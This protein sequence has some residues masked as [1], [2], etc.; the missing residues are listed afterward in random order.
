VSGDYAYFGG[1]GND[2]FNYMGVDVDLSTAATATLHFKVWFDI[3]TDWDYAYVA[4][5]GV[6]IPGNITTT[7]DPNGQNLGYGITGNSAGWIDAEFDLTAFAGSAIVIEMYYVTDS[8]VEAEGIYLDDI[9]VVTDGGNLLT[10]DAETEP[11]PFTLEG[12]STSTGVNFYTH[13]YLAEWRS[14]ADMD[15]GLAHVNVANQMLAFNEGMVL[16]YVD[17]SYTDNWVG[18]HP[19]DGF[20]GVVDADQRL[21]YWSDGLVASTRYQVHD[22]AFNVSFSDYVYLD[23]TEELG[24]TLSDPYIFPVPAFKDRSEYV[25]AEIPDAGRN[26]P[27]YGLK[28]RVLEHSRDSSVALIHLKK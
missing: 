21:N 24:V 16:W 10:D 6:P 2:L 25:T 9:A 13:Y 7:E 17:N 12:F 22:A 14:Y 4:V 20:L 3:E 19:G 1:K 26:I 23:L 27:N 5:N 11:S 15:T 18:I 8:F 28:I